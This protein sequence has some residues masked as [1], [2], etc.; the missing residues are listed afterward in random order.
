MLKNTVRITLIVML[1]A[2]PAMAFGQ[3][4]PSGKWWRISRVATRLNLSDNE[5]QQLED[6]YR[7]SRRKFIHLKSQVETEQ[8]ELENLIDSQSLDD[9][10]IQKQ[11]ERLE[12]AR[13]K[14]GAERFKFLIKVRKIVGYDRF[15]ELVSAKKN[16][17]SKRIRRDR[18]DLNLK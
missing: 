12:K 2:M 7:D 3:K 8:F 5:I 4:M 17:H 1:L 13:S 11:Y 18:N 15:Q 10:A 16:H 14:L 6:A 9:A